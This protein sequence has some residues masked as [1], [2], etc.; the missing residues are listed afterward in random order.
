MQ[1]PTILITGASQGIGLFVFESFLKN[2]YN[3]FATYN[4]TEPPSIYRN[5]FFKVDVTDVNSINN[6]VKHIDIQNQ[7]IALIN[8]AGI[9]YNEYAHN[10]DLDKWKNV[11]DV[12][13]TG[14]FN[15]IHGFLPVM[16]ERNYGRII[17]ISSVV[18]QIGAIGT[19][20]Y[21]ASK[22]GLWGM[23]KSIAAENASLNILINNINLGYVSSGMFN[24]IPEKV[25]DK[26]KEKIPMKAFCD[27]SE[28]YKSILFLIDTNY[29]SGS[30][31][32]VNGGLY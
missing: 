4:N 19:S 27:P 7:D 13:L 20:A 3:V 12:N 26:I 5:F 6:W 8:C 30:S 9:A 32:D 23:T 24:Q 10:S 1:K 29:I 17:N 14:T 28:V 21:A 18:A 11:I 16:R 22:S 15:V 2:D 31:I 25:K